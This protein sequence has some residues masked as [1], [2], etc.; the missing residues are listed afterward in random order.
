MRTLIDILLILIEVS[1]EPA[2]SLYQIFATG[3][4]LSST[5]FRSLLFSSLGIVVALIGVG[6]LLSMGETK[7]GSTGYVTM[8][9]VALLCLMLLF[10]LNSTD[11]AAI[12]TSVF[13][14]LALGVIFSK[15]ALMFSV[16]RAGVWFNRFALLFLP[17]GLGLF[18]LI[19]FV[20]KLD[21][22]ASVYLVVWFVLILQVVT[23]VLA[24]LGDVN[25]LFTVGILLLAMIGTIAEIPVLIWASDALL[26]GME[27]AAI[28]LLTKRIQL[29]VVGVV[30]VSSFSVSGNPLRPFWLRRKDEQV[31]HKRF[32]GN[33]WKDLSD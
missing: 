33:V 13:W 31:Y 25:V 29:G 3:P 28:N 23:D 21:N 6:A 5:Y 30:F 8:G 20:L 12:E 26:P 14:I 1:V 10:P 15:F 4:F 18:F 24:D 7:L 17:F 22:L 32:M 19:L 16:M 2:D 11:N 27:I 9:I